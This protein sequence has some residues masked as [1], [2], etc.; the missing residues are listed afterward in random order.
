MSIT[1]VD[2][3]PSEFFKERVRVALTN[4]NL[5]LDNEVEFYLVTLLCNFIKP[6]E[7]LDLQKLDTPLALFLKEALE[8]SDSYEQQE[9]FK[10][11]GDLS[12]YVSGY[13][14]ESFNRKTIDIDYY[15]AIGSSAYQK[16][17]ILSAQ[18]LYRKLAT[19]FPQLI[20]VVSEV[21][22]IPGQDKPIDILATYDRWTRSN[23]KRLLKVLQELGIDP[24]NNTTRTKQ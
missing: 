17:A 9:R 12:L 18:G 22:M 1:L 19:N 6:Q 14:Q 23:S 24:I 13:F 15:I 10:V 20:E 3:R 5:T 7:T 8:S 11:L 4:S 2:T 21:T 16:V